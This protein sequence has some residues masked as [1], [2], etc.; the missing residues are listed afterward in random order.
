VKRQPDSRERLGI[1][2]RVKNTPPTP[3]EN[4]CANTTTS[5]STTK[6]VRNVTAI[7]MMNGGEISPR[8]GAGIGLRATLSLFEFD[9]SGRQSL[10]RR[11]AGLRPAL[12]CG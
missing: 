10:M 3:F 4:A 8:L 5:G 6:M 2:E 7:A 1:G 12:D 11:D 9:S